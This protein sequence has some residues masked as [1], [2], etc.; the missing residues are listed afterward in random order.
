M[1]TRNHTIINRLAFVSFTVRQNNCVRNEI[2]HL[3]IS[4]HFV[5]ILMVIL[6]LSDPI[7]SRRQATIALE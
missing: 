6:R 4:F 2:L 3:G 5:A 1:Y 7:D